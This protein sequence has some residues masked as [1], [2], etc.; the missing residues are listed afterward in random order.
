VPSDERIRLHV[1]QRIPPLE[2]SA[3]SGHHPPGRIVG[4]SWFN[5]PPLEEGQLLA[6]EEILRSQGTA[7]MRREESQS[8]QVEHDQ[9][10]RPKAVYNGVENR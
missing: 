3:H 10:Q 4:S 8:D 6:K 9:G 7:G 5:L 2:D 1:H